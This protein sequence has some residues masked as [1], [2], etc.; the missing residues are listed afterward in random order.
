[1]RGGTAKTSAL[2]D[3]KKFITT[4]KAQFHHT[5]KCLEAIPQLELIVFGM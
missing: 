2:T 5:F 1:V 4:D 3:W